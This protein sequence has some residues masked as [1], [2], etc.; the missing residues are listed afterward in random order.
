MKT[1]KY[2]LLS[3]ILASSTTLFSQNYSADI[4][5]SILTWSASKVT[6]SHTGDINLLSGEIY[7]KKEKMTGGKFEI[8]MRTITCNDLLDLGTN[9]MLVKHLN[10]EDFFHTEKFSTAKLIISDI[11]HIKATKYSAKG[12]LTI[13]GITQDISF[14]FDAKTS[15]STIY[16]VG[17]IVIDRTKYDIKYGS[18]SFF[19]NLG[20]KMIDDNFSLSVKIKLTDNEQL[21]EN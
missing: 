10:S 7:V 6:G 1:I 15:E 20:D 21:T 8:D 11:N 12:K 2:T 9:A 13:K 18:G 14:D 4:S 16:A 5:S 3:L 19:S 17:N